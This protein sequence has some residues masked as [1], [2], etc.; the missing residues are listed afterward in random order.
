M[1]DLVRWA[2]LELSEPMIFGL[3][4]GLAFV[5]LKGEGLSPTRAIMGR[6]WNLEQCTAERLGVELVERNTDSPEE[7][8]EHVREALEAD[9][10]VMLQCDLKELPYW[11][12]KT[13]FNGH[14]IVVAGWD[15]ARQIALVADTHFEGLQ[16]V[17]LE[18]L[19][20][21]RRSHHGPMG[22]ARHA[23]WT[24][25]GSPVAP[26]AEAV[27][28]AL[29]INAEAMAVESDVAG[30]GAMRIFAD[31]VGSW[32]EQPDAAWCYRYAYQVI[33]KRGTGGANF[34]RLYRDYLMEALELV[35]AIKEAQLHVG[36]SRAASAWTTLAERFQ[37]ASESQSPDPQVLAHIE[38]L[39]EAVYQF[40]SMFWD[41]VE[42]RLS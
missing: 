12:S 18:A 9:K 2:G 31:D 34:R 23:S 37:F 14:R 29:K 10:P 6:G 15:E 25:E 35:P 7:A 1:R 33:E 4:S 13:P 21:S 27:L 40:E 5:Y 30:L 24:L 22:Y 39:A 19:A 32:I 20:L 28:K 3:G 38:S 26:D 36:M 8:W 16:E 41:Q 42:E 11:G 17:P